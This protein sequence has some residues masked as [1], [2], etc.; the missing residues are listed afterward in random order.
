MNKGVKRLNTGYKGLADIS[1]V[2]CFEPHPRFG[3]GTRIYLHMWVVRDLATATRVI[4]RFLG[5]RVM[6][7]T[8]SC[9]LALRKTLLPGGRKWHKFHL[10]VP[11]AIPFCM[12]I[13]MVKIFNTKSDA[14]G[15]MHI[16]VILSLF[17]QS[18]REP[19]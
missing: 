13:S 16:K 15:G 2:Q 10:L 3:H 4:P 9:L 5:N 17:T 7:D 14:L 11:R 1:T 8:L 19:W 6:K 12:P 18:P